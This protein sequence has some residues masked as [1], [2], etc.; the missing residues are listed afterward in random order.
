MLQGLDPGSGDVGAIDPHDELAIAGGGQEVEV[1]GAAEVFGVRQRKTMR[2]LDDL[3][4]DRGRHR[5]TSSTTT[6]R[7][8]HSPAAYGPAAKLSSKQSALNR[9]PERSSTKPA[10]A[11]RHRLTGVA[12]EP[13]H[14]RPCAGGVSTRGR[15]CPAPTLPA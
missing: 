10:G 7:I 8:I 2:A 1:G 13:N 6:A 11:D 12:I 4:D 9:T 3:E 14:G 15:G 5:P